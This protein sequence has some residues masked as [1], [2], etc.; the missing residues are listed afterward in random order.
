MTYKGFIAGILVAGAAVTATSALAMGSD[1]GPRRGPVSF[2][3]LD[4]DGNGEITL[5]EIE[6][7]AEARFK[8]DDANGDGILSKDEL[9]AAGQ[10]RV[11]QRVAKMI[12]RFD[13]DGD[14]AL[15]SEELPKPGKPGAPDAAREGKPGPDRAAMMFRAA[16][17]DGDGV[18]TEEE[19]ASMQDFMK[20]YRFMEMSESR[21]GDGRMGDRMRQHMGEHMGEHR[22]MMDRDMHGQ[23]RPPMSGEAPQE[24]QD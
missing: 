20:K 14:G 12:E 19:F 1:F 23:H 21:R 2:E 3:M 15:S 10:A 17:S 16:D 13:K 4:V 7:R 11:E 6:N 24:S 5:D 8:A 18:V 22:N 9:I